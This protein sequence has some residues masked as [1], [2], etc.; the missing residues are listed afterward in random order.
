MNPI[1][2]LTKRRLGAYNDGELGAA[3]RTKIE[4]HV[5]RCSACAAQ[6]AALTDLRAA[7]VT[8]APEPPEAVWE[9]FWPHVRRR[10][11]TSP[12]PEV[13]SRWRWAWGPVAGHPRL[14]LGSVLAAV[15]LAVLAVVA[16]WQRMGP[17]E[18]GTVVQ[19]PAAIS[20]APGDAVPIQRVLVQS[21]ETADPQSSVMVFTNP[22]SDITVVWVFGLPRTE[23]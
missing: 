19:A 4:V 6:L 14:A 12:P 23:I 18:R 10:I 9:A 5:G 21:V 17:P 16:P 15:T 8:L 11:A 2:W 13:E 1:C 22:E 3:A 20:S 7:L